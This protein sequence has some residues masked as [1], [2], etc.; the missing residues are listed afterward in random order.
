MS[1]ADNMAGMAE[2]ATAQFIEG[3]GQSAEADGLPRIAGRLWGFFIIHDGEVSLGELAERLRVSRGSISTNARILRDLGILERV[4]HPGDRQDYYRLTDKPYD[5]LLLGYVER[6]RRTQARVEAAHAAL[7]RQQASAR[8]R[9]SDMRRFYQT[10]AAAT[11][12]LI[13]S[14]NQDGRRR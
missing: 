3:M 7:P 4:T 9:L 5:R 1:A 14:F 13:A 8:R 6:M 12:K 2:Q 11:E 10:A